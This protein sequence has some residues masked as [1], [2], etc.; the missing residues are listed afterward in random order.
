MVLMVCAELSADVKGPIDRPETAV[1]VDWAAG[2]AADAPPGV[3]AAQ[4]AWKYPDVEV[5]GGHLNPAMTEAAELVASA[6]PDS[7]AAA[8]LSAAWCDW[9]GEFANG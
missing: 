1:R 9:K 2:G 5:A 8:Q 3:P 4:V 7:A 6:G